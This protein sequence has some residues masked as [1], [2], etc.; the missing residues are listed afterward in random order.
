MIGRLR[1]NRL[2]YNQLL[3]SCCYLFSNNSEEIILDRI[4]WT[5]TNMTDRNGSITGTDNDLIQNKVLAMD[6]LTISDTNSLLIKGAKEV[7]SNQLY[8]CFN[9]RTNTR[10]GYLLIVLEEEKSTFKFGNLADWSEY[11]E[12]VIEPANGVL[13]SVIQ[14]LL[15]NYTLR[16]HMLKL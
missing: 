5:I 15:L 9:N 4:V 13:Q 16:I 3:N 12:N 2:T 14:V 7:H 8:E 1:L 10:F 6:N 11:R